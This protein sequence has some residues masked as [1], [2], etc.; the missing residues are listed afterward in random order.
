MTPANNDGASP[1]AP[2][3]PSSNQDDKSAVTTNDS[4]DK[5][6]ALSLIHQ[7]QEDFV[8]QGKK[9]CRDCLRSKTLPCSKVVKVA[10]GEF[11]SFAANNS[12]SMSQILT[13]AHELLLG[14]SRN[15]RRLQTGDLS[16]LD[17]MKN[18][19]VGLRFLQLVLLLSEKPQGDFPSETTVNGMIVSLLKIWTHGVCELTKA[20]AGNQQHEETTEDCMTVDA[21]QHLQAGPIFCYAFYSLLRMNEYVQTRGAMMVP[22]WKGLCELSKLLL[23]SPPSA[24]DVAPM[25]DENTELV[26]DWRNQL[27]P[28]ILGDAIRVLGDF[29]QE[30]KGRLEVGALQYCDTDDAAKQA[31]MDR[32]AFQGK[33]VGFMI[34]RMG[35]LLK[36]H[37]TVSELKGT[38]KSDTI[39]NGVWRSLL[40]LRGMAATLQ[41]LSS[42][43]T[44]KRHAQ[45][46]PSFLK[47]YCELAAK[48]GKCVMDTILPKQD[49]GRE[50]QFL[51]LESFLQSLMAT[52]GMNFMEDDEYHQHQEYPQATKSML[53]RIS[54]LARTIGKVSALQQFLEIATLE[55]DITQNVE[56]LLAAVEHMH[57]I[58][59][60]QSLSACLIAVRCDKKSST[61]PTTMV[62]GSL[63][64][65]AK[66]LR[67]IEA[68]PGFAESP[69]QDAFYRLLLRWLAGNSNDDI[70]LREHPLSRDLVLSLLHAHI[71]G[72]TD[73]T[74][75]GVHGSGKLISLMTKLLFDVRTKLPLRRNIG[76][77]LVRLQGSAS[78]QGSSAACFLVTK[79][80]Q[81]EF[82]SWLMRSAPKQHSSK[83]RKRSR[84]G[85]PRLPQEDILVIARVLA[86][87]RGLSESAFASFLSQDCQNVLRKEF[88][89]LSSD[90]A[91][92]IPENGLL[93]LGQHNMLLLAWLEGCIATSPTSCFQTIRQMIGL[94]LVVDI[95]RPT[96]SVVSGLR[97]QLGDIGDSSRVLEQKVMLYSACMRL[98]SAWAIAFGDEGQLP[99]EKACLLIKYSISKDPWQQ[100]NGE[101][102]TIDE[103][104]SILKFEVLHLLGHIA[105]A[106][107]S[108][109]SEKVLKIVRRAFVFL[110]S[111]KEWAVLSS[112][113][114]SVS[115]FGSD[116]HASH[117]SILPL[118]LPKS[119][120][121]AFQARASSQVWRGPNDTIP[122]ETIFDIVE[123]LH[124]CN[125]TQATNTRSIKTILPCTVTTSIA[126][127][128]YI[129]E[130][131]TQDDRTATVIFPP[132]SQS[133]QDI[134]Y[135][136]GGMSQ[137]GQIPTKTLKR[138]LVTDGG[139]FK[140]LLVPS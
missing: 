119:S 110:M 66:T 49:Q 38:A 23:V 28:N 71:V 76:A 118:C 48:A 25:E 43:D 35:Q 77:L 64:V 109:C 51:A 32:I 18:I 117:Q 131:P 125:N 116:L 11:F 60:P 58:A 91:K 140:L 50:V 135:M 113:I 30:G 115:Q 130:M 62:L 97:F 120:M 104:H 41:L 103:Q 59:V 65:M 69:K 9:T 123:Q 27:P 127:G 98:F 102:P 75:H 55:S 106:I 99:I 44:F 70:G 124:R 14:M 128:S 86:A 114:S 74:E 61:T 94:D 136:M 15:F 4:D 129:L 63:R 29:L 132:G 53:I 88:T 84:A 13:K 134:R 100:K 54:F 137:D 112:G 39:P 67:A 93:D 34:A 78:T 7:L 83:K 20:C 81:N 139:V 122:H 72:S 79:M 101:N 108:N 2:T 3:N 10:N 22:L 33:F 111:S 6:I 21:T 19:A 45:L 107:P 40:G 17:C 121:G 68:S 126:P 24:E 42:S 85:A 133:L 89:R 46:E 26:N 92:E 12:T 1:V 90:Y 37:Y 56:A 105:K 80:V 57:S 82:A 73:E 16:S 5:K 138:A 31:Q 8:A 87:K 36:I 47:V 96:L 95:V 52:Q